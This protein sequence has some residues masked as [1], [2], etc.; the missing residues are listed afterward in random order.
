RS[1]FAIPT[2]DTSPIYKPF[3]RVHF[4]MRFNSI[5]I[6]SFFAS[7]V[8]AAPSRERS[9]RVADTLP[10]S[11]SAGDILTLEHVCCRSLEPCLA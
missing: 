6:S 4:V 2:S 8:L 10:D 3:T 11:T 1:A 5:L 9:Y 7:A